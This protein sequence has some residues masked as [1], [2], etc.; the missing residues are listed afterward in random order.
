MVCLRILNGIGCL[1]FLASAV[2]PWY[3]MMGQLSGLFVSYTGRVD[4]Q[5]LYYLTFEDCTTDFC[6]GDMTFY[7]WPF[8]SNSTGTCIVFGI[9]WVFMIFA[10]LSAFSAT[11]SRKQ[12]GSM[13]SSLFGLLGFLEF[14]F[15]TTAIRNESYMCD[16]GPCEHFS[17][18]VDILGQEAKWG[19][20]FGWIACLIGIVWMFLVSI[21]SCCCC[22]P[23]R[24]TVQPIIIHHES[25]PIIYSQPMQNSSNVPQVLNINVAANEHVDSSTHYNPQPTQAYQAQPTQAYQAQSTQ[26]YNAQQTTYQAPPLYNP[27]YGKVDYD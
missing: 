11:I 18:D 3:Y 21:I 10:T 5:F 2:L 17:G 26:E 25:S 1:L 6:S 9:A 14:F 16:T 12:S 19:P 27:Q 24:N 23:S 4:I 15:I 13:C 7:F 22:R 8:D 20:S